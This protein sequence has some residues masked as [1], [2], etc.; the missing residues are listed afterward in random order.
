MN[1]NPDIVS[2]LSAVIWPIIVLVIFFFYRSRI[3][4]V[5]AYLND[6][7]TVACCAVDAQGKPI[8]GLRIEVFDQNPKSPQNPLGEPA[9]TDEKGVALFRFKRSDFTNHSEKRDPD[10]YFKVYSGETVLDYLLPNIPDDN[11]VIQNFQ[12]QRDPIVLRVD[13]NYLVRGVIMQENGLPYSK[14][15][16]RLYQR[17]FGGL[18]TFLHEKETDENGNYEIPY[19]PGGAANIE[20]YGV[21]ADG[22]EIPLSR[23]KFGAATVEKMDLIG[24]AGPQHAEAEFSRLKTAISPHLGNKP[25]ALKNAIEREDRRDISLLVS[26]TGWDGRALALAS[27]AFE[28]ADK[29]EMPAEALYAL[30]RAGFPTDSKAIA[31]IDGGAIE[32]A[33]TQAAQAGIIDASVVKAGAKAFAEFASREHFNFIPPGKLAGLSHFV[34]RAM[35]NDADR[36]AFTAV[37]KQANGENLWRRAKDAGVSDK[38]I[39]TLRLQGKFAYLTLNN[40]ELSESL[41]TMLSNGDVRELIERD[42]DQATTWSKQIS[43]LADNDDRRLGKLL[44][45]A[46][47]GR[48]NQERL[49]AYCD[50]LARRVRQMDPNRVTLRQISRGALDGLQPSA[51]ELVLPFLTNAG[52]KGFRLGQTAFSSFMSENEENELLPGMSPEQ[53]KEAIN[54]VKTLHRLYSVSP[55]DESLNVLLK[56][57]FKSAYDI[58]RLPY[59]DFLRL[60]GPEIGSTRETQ[61]LYWKAQQQTTTVIDV[62]TGARQLGVS[63]LIGSMSSQKAKRDDQIVKAKERLTG[64]YPALEVLFGNIDYCECEH[65]KSVLSPAAY[66]VDILHFIDPKEPQWGHLKS[67]WAMAKGAPQEDYEQYYMKPFE[68][69]I[70]RRP[71]IPHIALTCENTNTAMPYIDIVNEILE[72]R[73]AGDSTSIKAFDTGTT[74]SQDLIAE[75]QNIT[76]EAYVAGAGKV[77]L[78]ECVYPIVLPFDLPLEMVRAFLNRLELPLWKLREVI[79]RPEMLQASEGEG[80]ADG[81]MDIWFERIGLGPCDVKILLGGYQWHTLYGYDDEAAAL[82]ELSNAKTLSRQLGVTYQELVELIKTGFVNP[83][84][85]NMV[86]L[87]QLAVDPHDVERYFNPQSPDALTDAERSALEARLNAIGLTEDDLQQLWGDTVREKILLLRPPGAGCDFSKTTLAFAKTPANST[88]AMALT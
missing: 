87:H 45:P 86:L 6:S 41:Q 85:D 21:F 68:A 84:L 48:N 78:N 40:V 55:S 66:L 58:T 76:W 1:I 75:P 63:P 26:T 73:V 72:L 71:D 30:Y 62:F 50:E 88:S 53:K 44:P 38:G 11:G 9:T 54:E 51:Q 49:L 42:F 81:L 67:L 59:P 69:L 3:P 2:I 14:S 39:E 34:T 5:M 46:F 65:C 15:K 32:T 22:K 17:G 82:T 43:T 37:V 47:E 29:A 74:A 56:K 36:T 16:V 35:V 70:K 77:G 83:A 57:G 25:E 8:A 27:I 60:V 19:L 79:G 7:Y 33:L 13:K 18:K 24:P 28:N 80:M 64:R 10:L 4:A 61:Q 31:R 52:K 20:V 23:T 12:Q